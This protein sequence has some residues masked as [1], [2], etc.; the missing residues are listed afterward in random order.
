[1]NTMTFLADTIG[2]A[3]SPTGGDAAAP[4]WFKI[5]GNSYFPLVIGLI[6]LM[7]IM[8]K[9]KGGKDKVRQ[10]MLK[11]LKRGDKIQTIGGILGTVLRTE[12]DRVEVKVDETNNTKMW[13]TRNAI[14]QVVMDE[15][16]EAK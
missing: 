16:T 10:D 4:W 15:K 13:F 5:F 12:E 3:T 11:Q 2:P 7:W 8:S 9:T 1:L 6:F 14:H